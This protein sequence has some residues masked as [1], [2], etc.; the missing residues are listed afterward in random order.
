MKLTPLEVQQKTF[1]K[2]MFGGVDA[3]EVDQFLDLVAHAMEDQT[4]DLHRL[5]ESL[6][7]KD[8]NLVEYRER[9]QMLQSTMTTAQRVSDDL[10]GSARKE[11]EVML[12]DAE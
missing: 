7:Q 12:S 10:K 5:Q 1:K 3:A 11:A 6:R 9:E 2:A 4:R 8:A